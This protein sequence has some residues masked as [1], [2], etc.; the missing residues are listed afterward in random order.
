MLGSFGLRSLGLEDGG[1]DA[2]GLRLV[3]VRRGLRTDARLE[4]DLP[5]LDLQALEP[6]DHLGV[7]GV[8]IGVLGQILLAQF[9]QE[10]L[11]RA[12]AVDL[13][14][15]QGDHQNAVARARP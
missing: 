13:E 6:A 5:V 7:L 11:R 3:R 14:R 9:R 15:L 1:G 10:L 4:D 8:V 2:G 12:L